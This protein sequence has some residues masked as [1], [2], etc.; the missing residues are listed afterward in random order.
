M[1][2]EQYSYDV[3]VSFSF[4]DQE[5]AERI[6]SDLTNLYGFSCW[7]CTQDINGGN[8]FR[9]IIPNKIKT[10]NV[11]LFLES[12]KSLMSKET[13]RELGIAFENGKTIIP[14]KLDESTVQDEFE[15]I[16]YGVNYIDG[17]KMTTEKGIYELAKAISKAIEKPLL[18]D[19]SIVSKDTLVSTPSVI[20]KTIFC[21][22]D[23]ILED[24]SAKFSEGERVIFLQGIGGIGKT[25]I[26]KQYAKK[27]KNKYDIIIYAT[28]SG[29]LIDLINSETPFEIEPE[30]PRQVLSGGTQEDDA[31]YFKRKLRKI[32]KLSNERTLIIIDNFD[33]E[34]DEALPELLRGKYHLL[35]TTRCDYSRL[36]PT[37]KIGPIDNMD[38]LIRVFIQNYQGYEVEKDDP[39]LI[40]LIEMVNCHTYTIELLAQHM[41]NSGQTISE[42]ISAL[43]RE[44]ILSL[45]ESVRQNDNKTQIAY[46]NLLK[47]FKV[48]SLTEEE[49]SVLRLLSM[50]PLSGVA[51]KDFKVW[52]QLY[53]LKILMNL[54]NRSWITRNTSGI[55]LHP[56]IRDV[57]HHVL[58]KS[59]DGAN[60]LLQ[61]FVETIRND[62]TQNFTI[63]TR[64]YY[65]TIA[66]ELVCL[67]EKGILNIEGQETFDIWMNIAMF[68]HRNSLYSKELIVL[69]GLKE[70]A[71]TKEQI[72]HCLEKEAQC[73]IFSG[74]A[75]K[76]VEI[77]ENSESEIADFSADMCLPNEGR[78]Y[79]GFLHRCIEAYREIGEFSIA[80]NY[81]N[82]ARQHIRFYNRYA[83]DA[84]AWT[85]YHLGR[86]YMLS[87]DYRL[88]IEALT[89]ALLTFERNEDSH[90]SG[91]C[92]DILALICAIQGDFDSAL[93]LNNKAC[94]L[95]LPILGN[96]HVDIGHNRKWRG[97]ILKSMGR[98]EDAEFCYAEAGRIY[99]EASYILV[100]KRN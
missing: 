45:N 86:T 90:A 96:K 65:A 34:H 76:A 100:S 81:A 46:E 15:Y 52:A 10:S 60:V 89:K 33:I 56:I 24:I 71:V 16:L 26:A 82:I 5:I 75:K 94:E 51:V 2:N 70:Y 54:E 53:S 73:Y 59:N 68:L 18:V 67:Y 21:G 99:H 7:I 97:D 87:G 62:S 36:Y 37:V 79:V 20:P 11:V 91:C 80:I 49:K 78:Y 27:N 47:M 6:V 50:M 55:A 35:F 29:S 4:A 85:E 98:L 40:Q 23:K 69:K 22:R 64:E 66:V 41:E 48:F 93:E 44:G 12:E 1:M 92:Y 43:Q 8:R 13:V 57:I 3:F 9:A 14:F 74:N 31:A 38:E 72:L 28:Y 25:E 88:G 17:T 42:M 61:K 95:M 30:L 84:L 19:T 63:A 83:G 32:Q 39:Q 77:I 58:L